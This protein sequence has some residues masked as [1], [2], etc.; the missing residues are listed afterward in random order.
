LI[1][2]DVPYPPSV[3]PLFL[4]NR[5][6]R[7]PRSQIL[8]AVTHSSKGPLLLYTL[9]FVDLG[10]FLGFGGPANSLGSSPT[11]SPPSAISFGSL[12]LTG[13]GLHRR[14]KEQLFPA[15]SPPLYSM[16]KPM[17]FPPALQEQGCLNIKRFGYRWVD[18]SSP[19]S[20]S[21]SLPCFR[22]AQLQT[23]PF[24]LLFFLAKVVHFFRTGPMSS[25]LAIPPFSSF[26][27]P[28]ISGSI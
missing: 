27:S 6:F 19:F 21:P 9:L 13:F 20:P 26:Q 25:P 18:P 2:L 8:R 14:Y 23:Y 7:R 22:S 17:R 15:P 24:W 28:A 1:F 5:L 12:Q 10:G 3:S 16:L 4:P 11:T